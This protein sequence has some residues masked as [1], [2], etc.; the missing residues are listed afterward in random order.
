MKRDGCAERGEDQGPHVDEWREEAAIEQDEH[1][2][3]QKDAG[4]QCNR[5]VEEQLGLPFLV[6]QVHPLNALREVLDRG[7]LIDLR[8]DV[9]FHDS[10]GKVGADRQPAKLIRTADRRRPGAEADRGDRLERYGTA[11]RRGNRQ[12]FERRDVAPIA[13]REG[14]L[15]WYLTV[16]QREFGT[17]LLDVAERGDADSLT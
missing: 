7:Q 10:G 4:D 6:A 12:V 1:C 5:E 3:D 14:D 9:A 2:E 8:P 17:V 11:V 13:I 15:N 16:R